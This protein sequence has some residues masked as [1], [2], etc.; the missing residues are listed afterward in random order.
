L[1]RFPRKPRRDWRILALEGD[2][3]DRIAANRLSA[4]GPGLVPDQDAS[5]WGDLL[6]SPRGVHRIPG[7]GGLATVLRPDRREHHLSASH[8]DPESQPTEVVG[9]LDRVTLE[10]EP[11]ANRA[12]RVVLVRDRRPEDRHQGVADHLVDPAPVMV[13]DLPHLARTTVD[14]QANLFGV[15]CLREVGETS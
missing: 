12:L 5:L 14:H 2:W 10:L 11:G 4:S 3:C 13:D 6:K 8:T 1:D 15:R 9:V 7:H